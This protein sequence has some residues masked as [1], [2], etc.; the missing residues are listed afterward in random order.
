M[1]WPLYKARSVKGILKVWQHQQVPTTM[2]KFWQLS[3][4]WYTFGSPQVKTRLIYCDWKLIYE[5][6]H[7]LRNNFTLKILDL[8]KLVNF[9][10]VSKLKRMAATYILKTSLVL[11][12]NL[13]KLQRE[14]F[15][16]RSKF[17]PS[18]SK[19]FWKTKF[20]VLQD[21][22]KDTIKVACV[23][24]HRVNQ[25]LFK[26]QYSQRMDLRFTDIGLKIKVSSSYQLE[27]TRLDMKSNHDIFLNWANFASIKTIDTSNIWS[28]CLSISACRDFECDNVKFDI[29]KEVTEK[30]K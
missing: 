29:P 16:F 28:K 13:L 10:K 11:V 15:P 14:H 26:K 4:C 20:P 1:I 23:F 2:A 5:F 21:Q 27:P 9:R 3:I 25:V 19:L 17:F 8:G 22:N 24:Q 18:T 12:Q 7:E 6:P 30:A